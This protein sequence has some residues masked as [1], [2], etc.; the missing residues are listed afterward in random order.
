MPI[1][2]NTNTV[3]ADNGSKNSNDYTV[4]AKNGYTKYQN[5]LTGTTTY[6]KQS[7]GNAYY[8]PTPSAQAYNRSMYNGGGGGGN[9]GGA[10]ALIGGV[11]RGAL[12]RSQLDSWWNDLQK[13]YSTLYQNE[14]AGNEAGFKSARDQANVK[15][16]RNEKAI[17]SM[18]GPDSGRTPYLIAGNNNTWANTIGAYRNSLATANA[19]SL[20]NYHLNLANG[21][22]TYMQKLAQYMEM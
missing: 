21:R 19:N 18:L 2:K 3:Q 10:N 9:V 12:M 4:T 22:N 17:R 8:D 7:N 14:L 5:N 13:Y 1:L 20:A 16:V 11:D 6:G 15:K